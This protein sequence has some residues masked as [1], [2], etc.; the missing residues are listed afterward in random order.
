MPVSGVAVSGRIVDDYWTNQAR[1][2]T[3]GADGFATFSYTGPCGVG[4]IAF[5]VDGVQGGGLTL[6]GTR[7]QLLVWQ[8]PD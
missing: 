6:D 5:L 8:I 4:A 7:G 2:E 1:V 3:T